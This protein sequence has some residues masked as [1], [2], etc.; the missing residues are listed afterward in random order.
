MQRVVKVGVLTAFAVLLSVLPGCTGM[1]QDDLDATHAK[2]AELQQ[3]VQNA[4]AQL[5]S[6]YRIVNSLDDTHTIIPGSF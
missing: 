1:V 6:L 3:L 5:E 2:L 4:N